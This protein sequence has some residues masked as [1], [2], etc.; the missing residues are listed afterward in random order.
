VV[1]AFH[2]I[3]GSFYESGEWDL[4]FN[5]TTRCELELL[6]PCLVGFVGGLDVGDVSGVELGIKVSHE[7]GRDH[8][9]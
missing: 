8:V 7:K 6:D 1:R 4:G 5:W 2:H 3:E 9:R